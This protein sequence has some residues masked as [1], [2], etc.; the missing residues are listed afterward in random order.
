MKRSKEQTARTKREI[1]EGAA[2]LFRQRGLD[3]VSVAEVMERAG[4]THGGFYK[5][6]DSKEALLAEAAG[7][8][9]EETMRVWQNVIETSQEQNPVRALIDRYLSEKHRKDLEH[10]CP[11]VALGGEMTRSSG[12][13]R[14]IFAEGVRGMIEVIESQ[15]G[16]QSCSHSRE[17]AVTI[18]ACMVGGMVIARCCDNEKTADSYLEATRGEIERF[19]ELLCK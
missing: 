16:A 11:V 1:I 4:L 2:A 14:T 10:G 15:L 19:R 13:V 17:L 3:G 18:V 9:F 7:A 12:A 6:F 8:A 5:H